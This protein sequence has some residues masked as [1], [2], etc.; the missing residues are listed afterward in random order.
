MF[1]SKIYKIMKTQVSKVLFIAIL[2]G[3]TSCI[4]NFEREKSNDFVPNRFKV[5]IPTS[6][7]QQQKKGISKSATV[8]DDTLSGREIY[9]MLTHFISI[10]NYAAVFTENMLNEI[11]KHNIQNFIFLSYSGDEDGRLKELSVD[12]PVDF[13]GK[14]WEYA[15]TVVDAESKSEADGG[16]AMQIFWN[17]GDIVDGISILKPYNLNRTADDILPETMYRVDYSEVGT[18][19]YDKTMTVEIVNMSNDNSDMYRVDNLKMFAGEKDG[20][21]E[22]YGNSNHPDAQFFTDESGFNWAFVASSNKEQDIAVAEVGLPPSELNSGSR[23]VILEEYS[24]KKVME[25]Q[26]TDWL[27]EEWNVIPAQSLL[28]SY[29]HNAA[30]PGYFDTE[31]FVQGGE[32]PNENYTELENNIKN[33]S[34]FNPSSVS[35]LAINFK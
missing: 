17:S 24:V 26:V 1:N 9:S 18:A 35:N 20:I 27:L 7:S 25:Q 8:S 15:L 4:E 28:D 11:D 31:G 19:N 12:S 10:G 22:L 21:V 30:S 33:L 3:F 13:D 16:V 23:F 32:A 29:L 14:S 6:L 2:F 34:P 5:E